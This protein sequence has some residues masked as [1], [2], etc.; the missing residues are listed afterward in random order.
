MTIRNSN[1]ENDLPTVVD[2]SHDGSAASSQQSD[3]AG[4]YAKLHS[5]ASDYM[6][7]NPGIISTI[8]DGWNHAVDGAAKLFGFDPTQHEIQQAE[9]SFDSQISHLIPSDQ[10]QLV[11]EM[12]HAVLE[13]D[14]NGLTK[15]I[16][17]LGDDPAQVKAYVQELN[18]MFKDM[19]ADVSLAVSQDGHVLMYNK[20]G[21]SA[22]DIDPATGNTV[23]RPISVGLD[24]TVTLQPGEVLNG[25]CS[26]LAKQI[27]NGAIRS[28][29]DPGEIDMPPIWK[30][31][32]SYPSHPSG[33]DPRF[34][35]LQG[36]SGG[37]FPSDN[38]LFE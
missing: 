21:Q 2:H 18:R 14:L 3:I 15:A 13:G 16:Q 28:S 26:G 35:I 23:E 11:E 24:G 9:N 12:G 29:E 38:P 25:D 22:I 27:G 19:G 30:H 33:V 36:G 1:V 10:K 5:Q 34:P 6:R 7:E 4:A 17:Q 31:P 8:S 20:N 37:P 32:Y